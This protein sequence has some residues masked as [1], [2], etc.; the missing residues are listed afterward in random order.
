M[1]CPEITL[2]FKIDLPVHSWIHIN[3][4]EE[5]WTSPVQCIKEKMQNFV[6]TLHF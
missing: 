5:Y 2:I 6:K 3:V 4:L 1:V